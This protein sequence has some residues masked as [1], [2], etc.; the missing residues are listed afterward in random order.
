MSYARRNIE[1]AYKTIVFPITLSFV[2]HYMLCH[3]KR[4]NFERIYI[5]IFAKEIEI[6][7]LYPSNIITELYFY[8]ILI[9]RTV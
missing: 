1:N 4:K 7:L 3:I 6:F 9:I 2:R 8:M 5:V